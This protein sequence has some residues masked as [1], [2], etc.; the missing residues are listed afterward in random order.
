LL[1]ATSELL[2]PPPP[3]NAADLLDANLPDAWKGTATNALAILTALSAKA[4]VNLP[5]KHVEAAINNA[6]NARFIESHSETVWPTDFPGASKS[7]FRIAKNVV[8]EP[9]SPAIKSKS[10]ERRAK[11][12]DSSL[13]DF[14]DDVLPAIMKLKAKSGLP[15]EFEIIVRIGSETEV[16]APELATE[17]QAI[18][19]ESKQSFS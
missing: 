10:I 14:V 11:L 13:Q 6:L 5:W 3:I 15:V 9:T 17:L 1:N 2:P 12:D 7:V 4:G 18:L 16:L 19:A 8:N